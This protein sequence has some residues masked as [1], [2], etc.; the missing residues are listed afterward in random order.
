M[1]INAS[2]KIT[3][4]LCEGEESVGYL[5]VDYVS[6]KNNNV[7][8]LMIL[9]KY[10]PVVETLSAM[11][12]SKVFVVVDISDCKAGIHNIDGIVWYDKYGE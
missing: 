12:T 2:V 9:C 10:N 11:A 3:V 5:E 1:T 6:R 8:S 7:H 4:N